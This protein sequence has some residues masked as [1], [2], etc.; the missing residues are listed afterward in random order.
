MRNSWSS[1]NVPSQHG[2]T[3]VVT[4]TGGFG[5]EDDTRAGA[6]MWQ[7]HCRWVDLADFASVAAFAARD[8]SGATP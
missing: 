2:R 7:R 6:S 3:I 1:Q 5:F 8:E 4:N